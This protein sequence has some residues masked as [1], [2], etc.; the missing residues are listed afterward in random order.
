M[1]FGADASPARMIRAVLIT[2]L[3]FG[4]IITVVLWVLAGPRWGLGFVAGG[5]VGALNLLLLTS[6]VRQLIRLAPRNAWRIAGL[7]AT[8]VVLVYGGLAALLLWRICPTPAIVAG[9]SLTLVVIV[10]K[11]AGRALITGSL[12]GGASGWGT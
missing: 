1:L 2:S 12:S 5:I 8:K 6:I 9:F 10:L 7:I 11:A 3:W 4:A